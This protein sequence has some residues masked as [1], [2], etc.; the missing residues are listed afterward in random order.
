MWGWGVLYIVYG[1]EQCCF[2]GI[3]VEVE[4]VVSIIIEGN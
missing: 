1:I 2:V 3:L 4:L